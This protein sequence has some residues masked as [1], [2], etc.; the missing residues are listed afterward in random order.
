[1]R[2]IA[3]QSRFGRVRVA[4]RRCFILADDKPILARDVL[5]RAFPRLKRFEYWQHWSVRRALLRDAEA[6]ARNRFGRGRPNLW[7]LRHDAT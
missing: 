1:M 7:A 4:V 5:L 3:S 6:I 2:A